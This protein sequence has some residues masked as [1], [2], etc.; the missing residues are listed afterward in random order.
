MFAALQDFM[1]GGAFASLFIVSLK[2]N[3]CHCASEHI[4]KDP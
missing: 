4:S 2:L 1:C 3:V